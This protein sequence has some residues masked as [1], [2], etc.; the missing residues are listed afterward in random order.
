MKQKR[1]YKV[2]ILDRETG[3]K[4]S[5]ETFSLGLQI[6]Q[7]IDQVN[8]LGDHGGMRMY[9]KSADQVKCVR[10]VVDYPTVT[11]VLAK[12]KKKKVKKNGK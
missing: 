1:K 8:Y 3:E 12:P 11:T 7:D 10:I 2:T 9:R 6:S 5:L 4:T